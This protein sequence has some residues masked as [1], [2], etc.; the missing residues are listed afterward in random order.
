MIINKRFGSVPQAIKEK[1]GGATTSQ[2]EDWINA[3]L[4]AASLQQIFKA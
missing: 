3:S 4:D 2:L 1:I